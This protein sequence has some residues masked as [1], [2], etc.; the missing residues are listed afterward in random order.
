ME[1]PVEGD[2]VLE[3][4]G[5]LHAGCEGVELVDRRL[6]EVRHAVAQEERL[7]AFAH[8]IHLLALGKAQPTH[9]GTRVRHEGHEPFAFEHPQRLAHGEPARA[10]PVGE[11]FL[12]NA[13]A[14][15]ELARED[16]A[17]QVVRDAGTR[18]AV[19]G[20][21]EGH[22]HY[23]ASSPEADPSAG[24]AGCHNRTGASVS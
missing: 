22:G 13:R 17:A 3:V 4:G 19:R 16:R 9:P 24:W 20:G 8:L 14:R 1:L 7:D 10:V 15:L 6:V 11:V 5:A 12:A 18:R 2:E 21:L 23:S